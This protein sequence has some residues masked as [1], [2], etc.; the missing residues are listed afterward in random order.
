MNVANARVGTGTAALLPLRRVVQALRDLARRL[1]DQQRRHRCRRDALRALQ[2]LD[3]R[4]LHDIGLGR[5][6]IPSAVAE[7]LG[8]AELTRV[9]ISRPL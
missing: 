9:R 6:E 1:A 4:G 2:A 3:T 7:W 8:E 5:S